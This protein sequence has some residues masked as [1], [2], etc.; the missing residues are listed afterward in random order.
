[1]GTATA[2]AGGAGQGAAAHQAAA[3]CDCAVYQKIQALRPFFITIQEVKQGPST[4][5]QVPMLG[6]HCITKL[7]RPFYAGVLV[8]R[9]SYSMQVQSTSYNW[10]I[11]RPRCTWAA[12][13]GHLPERW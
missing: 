13:Q 7:S 1:M 12:A 5:Q 11:S 6:L 9:C 8:T 3:R 4:V 10:S 2:A